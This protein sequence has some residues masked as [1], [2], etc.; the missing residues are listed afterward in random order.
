[1]VLPIRERVRIVR[2]AANNNTDRDKMIEE[3][4]RNVAKAR[5]RLRQE[6]EINEPMAKKKP[7]AA[8]AP[9]QQEATNEPMAPLSKKAKIGSDENQPKVPADKKAK[10]VEKNSAVCETIRP[11]VLPVN[12]TKK[13]CKNVVNT[14]DDED[15]E[16]IR[17]NVLS[18]DDEEFED[19]DGNA[20]P[21]EDEDDDEDSKDK[22]GNVSKNTVSRKTIQPMFDNNAVTSGND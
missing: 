22:R 12:L 16:E 3:I 15:S 7:M 13:V 5:E 2:Q 21:S 17:G 10:K 20:L 1:M 19:E 14:S 4:R 6:A 11:M 9:V 18:S 8:K